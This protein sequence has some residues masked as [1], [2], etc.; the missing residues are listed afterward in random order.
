MRNSLMI[1][2]RVVVTCWYDHRIIQ[3][4]FL[5]KQALTWD[6]V[7][8]FF[9]AILFR[10]DSKDSSPG[11]ICRNST[12]LQGRVQTNRSWERALINYLNK[13]C[14][15]QSNHLGPF[16]RLEASYFPVSIPRPRG[17]YAMR[18]MPNES[19]TVF[20]SIWSSPMLSSENWTCVW[21][22]EFWWCNT[23]TGVI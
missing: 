20:S 16:G 3:Q 9:L 18:R 1:E 7:F 5:H 12:D 22:R 4:A 21:L 14:Q 17:L 15:S 19:H 2:Y 13:G 11:R 6:M 10:Q 23:E 8:P